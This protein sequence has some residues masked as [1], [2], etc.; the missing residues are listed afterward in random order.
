[1][2][3][4]GFR[5]GVGLDCV[6]CTALL[7]N[8]NAKRVR[9]RVLAFLTACCIGCHIFCARDIIRGLSYYRCRFT[10]PWAFAWLFELGLEK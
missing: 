3:D 10:A 7:V 9:Q 4:L 2:R 6:D 5:F 8:G 1:M